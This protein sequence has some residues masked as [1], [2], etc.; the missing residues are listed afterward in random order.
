VM[1]LVEEDDRPPAFGVR[2]LADRGNEQGVR[3]LLRDRREAG[4]EDA[5]AGQR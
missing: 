1:R 4:A 3:H 2:R 5:R